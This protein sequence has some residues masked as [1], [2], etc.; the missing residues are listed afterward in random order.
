[1]TTAST[2]PSWSRTRQ[3]SWLGTVVE[4]SVEAGSVPAFLSASSFAYP[5]EPAAVHTLLCASVSLYPVIVDDLGARTCW[6]VLKYAAENATCPSR[7]QVIVIVRTT[8]STRPSWIAGMRWLVGI[9]L[10]WTASGSP[11]MSWAIRCTR[12]MSKPSSWAPSVLGLR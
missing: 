7:S 4:M 5:V 1:M 3:S 6:P 11:R 8:M 12:S 10:N 2:S 9:A